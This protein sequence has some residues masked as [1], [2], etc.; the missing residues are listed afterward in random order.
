[1]QVGGTSFDIAVRGWFLAHQSGAVRAAAAFVSKVGAAGP[2]RWTLTIAALPFIVHR[3]HRAAITLVVGAWASIAGYALPRRFFYR[4][5]PPGAAAAHEITSSFPSAHS[6]ASA[7]MFCTLAYV[8][9]RE[10]LLTTRAAIAI[11]VL[12]TMVIGLSRIVLDMHWATDV[13]S[14]W[15]IG[16]VVALIAA[17]VYRVLQ[18]IDR[19]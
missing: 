3:R 7:A 17:A 2:L 8:L 14:G 15:C 16:V 10:R 9:W 6:T 19:P 12:P 11:A 18:A 4:Q 5:R 13:L 1:M